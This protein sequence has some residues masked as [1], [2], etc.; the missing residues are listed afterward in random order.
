M[1]LLAPPAA[2]CSALASLACLAVA[3]TLTGGSTHS[4]AVQAAVELLAHN[5]EDSMWV[6]L[7]GCHLADGK[8][9][10]VGGAAGG[11]AVCC[12][13]PGAVWM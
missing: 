2:S 5:S 7:G 9:K 12:C 1:L 10:K 3:A 13:G 11:T 4:C 6:K 8:L